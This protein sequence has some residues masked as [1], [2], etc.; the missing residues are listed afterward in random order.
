MGGN[1]FIDYC[2]VECTVN[3]GIYV[4]STNAETV[5]NVSNSIMD[6]L[7]SCKRMITFKVRHRER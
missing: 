4:I 2:V 7:E 6:G 3:T 1:T 5:L